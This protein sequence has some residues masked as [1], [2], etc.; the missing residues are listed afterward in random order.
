MQTCAFPWCFHQY[1]TGALH[2]HIAISLVRVARK[3]MATHTDTPLLERLISALEDLPPDR[4]FQ[5][6]DFVGYLQSQYGRHPSPRGSA[7][8]IVQTIERVGPLQFAPG[9]LDTHSI[10]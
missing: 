3:A 5:V 10:I 2:F 9:E 8:A 1:T 4:L 7:Q 6:F